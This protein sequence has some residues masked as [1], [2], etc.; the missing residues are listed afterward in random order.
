MKFYTNVQLYGNQILIKGVEDGVRYKYRI[1][2]KPSMFVPSPKPSK[3]KTLHGNTVE[4]IQPGSIKE[5]RDFIKRYEGVENFSFYGTTQFHYAYIAEEF[6]E[7]LL[8]YDISK[9]VVATID[10]EV[11]SEHGFPNPENAHE[12][13]TAICIKSNN[14]IFV[15]GCGDY[16]NSNPHV[17]YIKCS[18]ETNLLNQFIEK[19]VEIGPDVISGWNIELFD[20]PYLVNR[21]NKLFNNK[22]ASQKLSPW[23]IIKERKVFGMGG[24]EHQAYELLGVATLDYIDLYKKFTYKSVESYRLDHI[25]FVE[26]GEKKL[27]YSEF[28]TLH[29]LYKL[30]YQKFID[31]NVKDVLLVDALDEKMKLIELAI[32]MAYDARVNYSDVHMQVRMWD[33]LIYNHLLRKGIV[34][35]PKKFTSKNESY[36]GAYVK[37]PSVGMHDWVVSFDLNSLY[38]HLIIQYNISPETLVSGH[39]SFTIDDLLE[40]KFNGQEKLKQLNY[41]LAPNGHYFDRKQQGFLPEMMQKMYNDRVKYKSKMIEASKKLESGQG[42]RKELI[43][44]ISKFNNIQM[45]KKISLNSAYGAIGNQYFRFFDI[46]L[47]EA[48]TYGGQ[49]SIRWVEREVNQYLNN[50][51]KTDS[52][53]YVLASDTDSIYINLGGLVDKVFKDKSDTNK[54][55]KFLDTICEEKLQQIIDNCYTNLAEYL[56]AYEQ[57]MYMKR[58]VLVDRA[59]WVAKKRYILNVHNS[60]GIQYAKPKLKMMGLES[61]KSSTPEVCRNKLKESFGLIMNSN[62]D[63]VIEF[64]EEF[65]E[66]FYLLSPE[67][68]AFPRS[69]KGLRKYQDKDML[70][71]KGT[72]IHV[73][74]SLIYNSL[75]KKYKLSNKYPLIQE[76][77]KIKF[78]YL[79]QPNPTG[80]TVIAMGNRMPKEFGLNQYIDYETQYEK[81]FVGPLK[82]ILNAIGWKTEQIANLE[83]FFS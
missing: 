4:K 80:D 43:N 27:D 20:I 16:V 77:E 32:A 18:N 54:I 28:D 69:V 56:N 57:K 8:D 34:I 58:E 14:N 63:D 65:R 61:I 17:E 1:D 48:V 37:D 79:K 60:E 29:Q 39:E 2:Y 24:R 7:E 22:K 21:I 38:P 35:P 6:T 53:D 75:L 78:A 46:R 11:G 12:E 9:I 76:G 44:E 25:A 19:W 71:I 81:S 73:K 66:E 55:I 3:F 40:N 50:L 83:G 5:T 42:N 45:A 68:V 74:G 26:L 59:I 30:D 36:A 33:V 64:I 15:Y 49:L 10:I 41:T 72:P 13:I 31:Y 47:A 67:Q 70:Y 82:I 23:G 62:E 52:I 51:L